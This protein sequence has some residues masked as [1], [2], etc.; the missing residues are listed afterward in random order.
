M[1]GEAF[2]LSAPYVLFGTINFMTCDVSSA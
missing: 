2:P 1:G